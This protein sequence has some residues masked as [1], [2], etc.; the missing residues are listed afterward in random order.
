MKTW[1]VVGCALLICAIPAR[2]QDC[3]ITAGTDA[4]ARYCNA[5]AQAAT[6]AQPTI[7]LAFTAGNPVPG[8]SSTL[9]MRIGKIPRI[10]VAGRIS[11]A[12]M[13]L[14]KVQTA[15]SSGSDKS[16]ARTLNVDAA[17]G[18]LSGWSLAPTIGGFGSLDLIASAGKL[19]LPDEFSETPSSWAVGARLG[20]LRESFTAPGISITGMYRR[21]GDVQYGESSTS[22]VTFTLQDNSALSVRAIAGKR[23]FVVGANVGLG[24]DRFSSEAQARRHDI[25]TDDVLRPPHDLDANRYT[26]FGNLTWTMLIL[27]AVIEGGYQRGGDEFTAP[28]PAGH[29]SR[30]QNSTYYG[31]LAIR[32]AL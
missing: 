8:A 14:P 23:L 18:I 15:T 12:F 31:S 25:P 24:Y 4:N 22:D 7:G 3:W 16:L 6:I 30:T 1:L 10:T 21:I 27:N 5:V 19:S 29:Q 2:A 32:L 11:G 26:A 13:N 20:I 17:V 28:L 9:G